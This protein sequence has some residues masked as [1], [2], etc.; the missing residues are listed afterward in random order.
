MP[1]QSPA[2][3][4]R[5][6]ATLM[7]QRATE[8]TPGSWTGWFRPGTPGLELTA[9][10]DRYFVRVGALNVAQAGHADCEHIIGMHPVFAL[11]VA[12]WL[13]RFSNE[14]YCYGPAEHEHALAI[15]RAYLGSTG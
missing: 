15:A 6:A 10:C 9:T 2:E 5:A 3:E 12:D 14:L 1:D 4:I 11:A 13:D 8:A 7:R